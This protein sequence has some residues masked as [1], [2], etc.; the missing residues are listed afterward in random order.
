MLLPGS[1]RFFTLSLTLPIFCPL[2]AHETVAGAVDN[3]ASASA[4]KSTFFAFM[5]RLLLFFYAKRTIHPTIVSIQDICV[6]SK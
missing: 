4:D 6:Q 3:N 2:A 1:R 5:L